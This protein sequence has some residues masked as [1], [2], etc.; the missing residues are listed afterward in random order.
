MALS[1][2]KL[3]A[4]TTQRKCTEGLLNF[5]Q[6]ALCQEINSMPL[7]A[8]RAILVQASIQIYGDLDTEICQFVL[9]ESSSSFP[10]QDHSQLSE[11]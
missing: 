5:D 7:S 9:N 4:L 8:A 10:S 1:F 2:I 11:F 6:M 3:N